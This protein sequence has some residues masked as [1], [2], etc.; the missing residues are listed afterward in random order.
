MTST[1]AR[2]AMVHKVAR[3]R[4]AAGEGG[5]KNIAKINHNTQNFR[6]CW[7]SNLEF[8]K[9][10]ENLHIFFTILSLQLISKIAA[11]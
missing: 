6:D 3:D 11:Q 2:A 9:T 10:R 8:S 1:E 4:N 7:N 5:Q